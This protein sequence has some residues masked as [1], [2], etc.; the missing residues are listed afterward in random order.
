MFLK[1]KKMTKIQTK[2]RGKLLSPRRSI[3][4]QTRIRQSFER[5]LYSDLI[6]FF[7][8]NGQIASQQIIDGQMHLADMPSR[9]S[10]IL[11]PHYRS[12]IISMANRFVF[13]KEETD[14]E[15]FVRRYITTFAGLRITQISE[16]T[17]KIINKIILEAE[18]EGMGVNETAK[19]IRERTKQPFTRY[20]SALIA[21]TE[22]HQVASFANNEMAESF[23]LPMKKRWVSTN[24]DRTREHHRAM[25]GVTIDINEDFLIFHKGVEYRMKHAGDPRGG[26]AN[27]INCRCVILYL[28]PEDEIIEE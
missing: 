24:D 8:R 20:R 16:T 2:R 23:N 11:L 5:K 1:E 10:Q 27:L 26:P 22:T 25:N 3:I 13:T 9:L 15:R 12:V 17:R 7:E 19:L 28:D 21:R 18:L 14:F 6:K 4:E